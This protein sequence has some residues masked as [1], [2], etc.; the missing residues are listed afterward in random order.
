M[1]MQWQTWTFSFL[2]DIQLYQALI[3]NER[4]ASDREKKGTLWLG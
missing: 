3:W 1:G 2:F 4:E